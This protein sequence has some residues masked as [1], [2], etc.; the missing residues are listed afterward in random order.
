MAETTY[1]NNAPITEALIDIRAKLPSDFDIEVFKS[2]DEVD[3][4]KFPLKEKQK[5]FS[6]NFKVERD[7]PLIKSASEDIRGYIYRSEDQKNIVQFRRD[8]F[9]YNRLKPYT[10]W[11]DVIDVAKNLWSIYVKYAKP[12]KVT[13][14]GTRYINQIKLPFPVRDFS[15]YMA[16]PPQNPY[17]NGSISGYLNRIKLTDKQEEIDVNITQ[18]L[19]KGTEKE[20]ITLLLDIDA[21]INR[22]YDPDDFKIWNH[23]E[24]LRIKKNDVFFDSITPK[25]IN[26]LQ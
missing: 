14:I 7:K 24:K 17:K 23:F 22:E 19:E 11:E 16:A 6:A 5:E 4:E 15:D 18:T 8:G 1:L 26:L 21:F 3:L 2:L 9:T 13:R 20:T 25:T 10:K 12:L